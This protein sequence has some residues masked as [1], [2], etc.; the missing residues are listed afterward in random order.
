VVEVVKHK[1][2]IWIFEGKGYV[3]DEMVAEAKIM[4]M[5]KQV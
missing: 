5:L 4:A 3:D 2:E 1:R